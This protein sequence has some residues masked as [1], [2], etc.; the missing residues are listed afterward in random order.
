VLAGGEALAYL[1][2]GAH[3]LLRFPAGVDDDRWAAALGA[4]VDSGRFRSLELRMVDGV[5]VHE[6]DATVRA[7]L[8]QAG[9]RPAYKG[10][11]RR[12]PRG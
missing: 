1:E 6:A 11:T 2:R 3:R 7:T 9:F 4:L 5:H 10:W 8:E 12:A